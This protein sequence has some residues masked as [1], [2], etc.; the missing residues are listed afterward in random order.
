LQSE[1]ITKVLWAASARR[2]VREFATAFFKFEATEAQS[3]PQNHIALMV[4]N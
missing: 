4:Q 3:I 1:W 2:I